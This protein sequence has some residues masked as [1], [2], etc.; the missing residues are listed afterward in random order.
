[1]KGQSLRSIPHLT[2]HFQSS[3]KSHT[4]DRKLH[5]G[6]NL[7]FESSCACVSHNLMQMR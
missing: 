2:D 4:A 7:R 6:A 1:M 5:S 3:A